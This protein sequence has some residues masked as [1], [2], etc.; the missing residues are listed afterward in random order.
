M[1]QQPSDERH[2]LHLGQTRAALP[3]DQID[4]C[5]SSKEPGGHAENARDHRPIHE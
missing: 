1:A 5:D 3:G 4:D 2:R